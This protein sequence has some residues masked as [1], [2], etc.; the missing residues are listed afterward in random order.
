MSVAIVWFRKS[1]RLDDNPALSQVCSDPS[2]QSVLPIFIL[3]PKLHGESFV[4]IGH[5][6]IRF[7]LESLE[8]L[9]TRIK[10]KLGQKLL[11]AQGNPHE[12]LS[13]LARILGSDLCLLTSDYCSEPYGRTLTDKIEHS[14]HKL[15]LIHI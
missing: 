9:S 11:F 5:A 7:L 15:S 8:D 4:K 10:E 14:F 13:T 12:I 1:L 6:R 3:D 2:I